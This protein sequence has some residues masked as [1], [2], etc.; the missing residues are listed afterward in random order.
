VSGN[1]S[2]EINAMESRTLHAHFDGRQIQLDEPFELEPN[3]EL[4]ITV[5]PEAPIREREEWARLSLESLARIYGEDEP[6]YA[7]DSI[8]EANPE[9]FGLVPVDDFRHRR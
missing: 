7:A 3:T 8:K 1:Q 2:E 5:L 9:E 4:L 6:E